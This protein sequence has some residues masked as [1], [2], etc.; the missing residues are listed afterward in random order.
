MRSK[1]AEGDH[2]QKKVVEPKLSVS[3]LAPAIGK[4][5]RP[6]LLINQKTQLVGKKN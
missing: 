3:A 6:Q 2:T 4:K 1:P 5:A